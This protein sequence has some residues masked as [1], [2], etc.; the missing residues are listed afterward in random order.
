VHDIAGGRLVRSDPGAVDIGREH[1]RV[2]ENAVSRVYAFARIEAND[3]RHST[4]FLKLVS[5]LEF[6]Q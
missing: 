1:A 3:D 4:V 2:S 5:H 6:L